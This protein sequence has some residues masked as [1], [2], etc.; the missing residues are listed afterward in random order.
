MRIIVVSQYPTA[1]LSVVAGSSRHQ[2][3]GIITTQTWR[4]GKPSASHARQAELV[5]E[6]FGSAY[7]VHI[8]GGD[9]DLARALLEVEPDLSIIRGFPW[10]LGP[11]S[12]KA[13]KRLT[14]NV[15]PSL[16]P[17]YRGPHPV[18]AA[19][20]RGDATLG[21][22]VHEATSEI[23]CG[24]V[25]ASRAFSMPEDPAM[26][27]EAV[28]RQSARAVAVALK[29]IEANEPPQPMANVGVSFAPIMERPTSFKPS[30]VSARDAVGRIQL[31]RFMTSGTEPI[32]LLH[33][34]QIVLCTGASTQPE[35]DMEIHCADGPIW[36][37]SL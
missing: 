24:S 15:H 6:V 17:K 29:A 10:R 35:Y 26:A 18:H 19:I 9:E 32:Q 12:L 22:T 27:W 8:V 11:A 2:I 13:S 4:S 31:H 7:P 1:I 21:I 3:V 20:R 16:L 34:E 37:R 28:D 36:V 5:N 23:D 33:D 14:L 25:F 30:L